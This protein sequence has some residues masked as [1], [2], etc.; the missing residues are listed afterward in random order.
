VIVGEDGAHA[1]RRAGG[2]ID[3]EIAPAIGGAEAAEAVSQAEGFIRALAAVAREAAVSDQLP[4]EQAGAFHSDAAF[5][6]VLK[7]THLNGAC[8]HQVTQDETKMPPTIMSMSAAA[9]RAPS[10]LR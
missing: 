3:V 7:K 2:G 10:V 1:A 5:A 6:D 4:A 8:A 9:M